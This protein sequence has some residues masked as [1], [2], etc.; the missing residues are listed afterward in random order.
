MAWG[1]VYVLGND[2]M[3]GIYKIGMTEKAPQE[4]LEQLSSATSVPEAFNMIFF[5]QVKNAL[6]VEQEMH[7]YFE[8]Y[9][10]NDSREFFRAPI[11]ELRDY[12]DRIVEPWLIYDH[13]YN[14][15]LYLQEQ[16]EKADHRR[17]LIEHFVNQCHDPIHWDSR[18]GFRGFE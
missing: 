4:R 9:R 15:E 12:I 1:F 17:S 6:K 16:Q 8:D 5:A 11:R 3:P 18:R 2:S 10:V 14:Y 7:R 13:M